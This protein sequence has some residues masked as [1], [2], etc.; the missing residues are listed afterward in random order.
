[1]PNKSP[2]DTASST[3]SAGD[4][5]DD[6]FAHVASHYS[7]ENRQLIK[8]DGC[9]QFLGVVQVQ[10][11]ESPVPHWFY[12]TCG[13]TEIRE[14]RTDNSEVS[15]FGFELTFRLKKAAQEKPGDDAPSWPATIL[16][17]F[18]DNIF[19]GM[20]PLEPGLTVDL[21]LEFD[22]PAEQL[23]V[24]GF[25]EDPQLGSISTRNGRV[26]FLQLVSL[27]HEEARLLGLSQ[28]TEILAMALPSMPLYIADLQRPPFTRD[29]SLMQAVQRKVEDHGATTEAMAV[30]ALVCAIENRL[31]QHHIM[32]LYL[33]T[34]DYEGFKEMFRAR[35]G[36]GRPLSLVGPEQSLVINF[37]T[38]RPCHLQDVQVEGGKAHSVELDKACCDQISAALQDKQSTI[39]LAAWDGLRI[40][41]SDA[42]QPV[43]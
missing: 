20:G 10:E 3:D 41:F 32:T 36:F 16:A 31:N 39:D 33:H 4:G 7:Q 14:K 40:E 26:Q 35:L 34:R 29:A 25:V 30:S 13:L 9:Q 18:A 23:Q 12:S 17:K 22:D 2:P 5:L 43:H 38:S 8:I 24:A 37:T 6:L 1:M 42:A 27:Y 28:P 15:G 21:D 11:S 19:A